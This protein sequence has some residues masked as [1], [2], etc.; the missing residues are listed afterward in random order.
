[1]PKYCDESEV[2]VPNTF[3]PNGDGNNDILFVRGKQ[4]KEL[5]FAV[6]NRRG[7]LVFETTNINT[8]W[9][10]IYNGAKADPDIFAWYLRAVCF[11][12]GKLQSKGNVTLVK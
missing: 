10:G 7:E 5:Y 9:N 6:Y 12:N 2:F 11:N 3:T 4:I 8:G 1:M